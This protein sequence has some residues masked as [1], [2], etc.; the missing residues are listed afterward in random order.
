MAGKMLTSSNSLRILKVWLVV[1]CLWE[2]FIPTEYVLWRVKGIGEGRKE[3][4]KKPVFTLQYTVIFFKAIFYR[5]LLSRGKTLTE[6]ELKFI[7]LS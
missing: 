6:N 7:A 4:E 5:R 1:L 2:M 3:A